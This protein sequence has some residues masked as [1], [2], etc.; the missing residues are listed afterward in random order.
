M[1]Q[2]G[3]MNL[4]ALPWGV[5]DI[6]LV[7]LLPLLLVG[8]AF[9]SGSETALFG[10]NGQQRA[11]LTQQPGVIGLAAKGLLADA[12][13][14][15]ITLMLGN[16]MVNVTYFVVSSS[17]A[18]KLDAK[19]DA[20]WIAGGSLTSLLA[21][22]VFGEVL[23]KMI[24]NLSPQRWLGV[25]GVPLWALHRVI[26][27]LRL[28]LQTMVIGP[29]GRLI[30]PKQRPPALSNAELEMLVTFSEKRGVID[31][32][33][34][35]MLREVV[36]LSRL[37]VRDV[38]VPR[39]DIQAWDTE[40][41]RAALDRLVYEQ[42]LTKIPACRG[43]LDHVRGIVYARQYLLSRH[44][45]ESVPIERFV[46]NVTFVPELQR[47]DQLL[48]Q[49]RG[50]GTHIAIAVDE[51]G[52]TA[53]LITLKDIVER[54]TG[55]LDFESDEPDDEV[56]VSQRI[57]PGRWRVSGR[58]AVHDWNQMFTAG[59]LPER[60]ATVG[61]LTTALLGRIPETGDV[62]K[63]A[64]LTLEVEHI[65]GGRVESVILSVDEDQEPEV[66]L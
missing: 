26:Y 9:F 44:R 39:V 40:D 45:D 62:A 11:R 49:F 36:A 1:I 20:A 42:K 50:D 46:R 66:S 48:E 7:L 35:Q 61:G 55:E 6:P 54:M 64:N 53:G 59:F 18:L 23:P 13:M 31:R 17:L 34:E 22:I 8:S 57:E 28:V 5:S 47:V 51:Y 4:A 33:E 63:L 56:P 41:G 25:T 37:K 60:V 24:A 58:L 27:P 32:T 21:V 52:G 65:E 10:M 43:D 19:T 16:M 2:P 15:L 3:M 12:Q 30:A 29:L 38:M 14:L